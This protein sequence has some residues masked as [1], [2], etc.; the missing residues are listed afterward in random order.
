MIVVWLNKHFERIVD[1][2]PFGN[3]LWSPKI[4]HELYKSLNK[5]DITILIMQ[6]KKLYGTT[7][8]IT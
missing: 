1:N 3:E 6:I 5:F 7:K 8:N 2:V 4:Q